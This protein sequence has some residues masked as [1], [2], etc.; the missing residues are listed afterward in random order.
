MRT[1]TIAAHVERRAYLVDEYCFAMR[2]SRASAYAMMSAG[3][4]PYF[5]V[6]NRRRIPVE[7]V[8]AQIRGELSAQA[9]QPNPRRRKS[10][11]E[12]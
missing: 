6:G 7:A 10:G 4:L 1:K 9:H 11:A 12:A 5:Y 8:E 2:V 3:M